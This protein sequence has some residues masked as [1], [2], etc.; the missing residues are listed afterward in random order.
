[1][2]ER[3]TRVD[4]HEISR[5]DLADELDVDGGVGLGGRGLVAA[6]R[7]AGSFESDDAQGE[8]LIAAGD[9]VLVHASRREPDA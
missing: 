2:N 9:A 6:E 4:E 5:G 7:E 3:H 8:A 1:M